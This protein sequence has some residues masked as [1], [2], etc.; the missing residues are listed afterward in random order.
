M[1]SSTISDMA[2]RVSLVFKC[3]VLGTSPWQLSSLN[4]KCEFIGQVSSGFTKEGTTKNKSKRIKNQ[5]KGNS[6]D[7][8]P[9]K[10]YEPTISSSFELTRSMRRCSLGK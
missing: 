5:S 9:V 4:P 6:S 10:S 3:Y 8:K 1:I 2:Y 7:K